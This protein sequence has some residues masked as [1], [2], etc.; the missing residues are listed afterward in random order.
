MFG[1]INF[2]EPFSVDRRFLLHAKAVGVS[3]WDILVN[4][5]SGRK[6]GILAETSVMSDLKT[7][8]LQNIKKV[9]STRKY[10]E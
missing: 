3:K 8:I 2:N 4:H 1:K 6:F 7:Y 10:I 9:L 5:V